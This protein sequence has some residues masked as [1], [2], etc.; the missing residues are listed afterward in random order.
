MDGSSL[1]PVAVVVPSLA[2]AL[3]RA[4]ALVFDFDGTLV[5]ST[6]IKRRAFELCFVEF[7]E[8]RDEILA[9]CWGHH[10]TPREV[11][12]RYVYEQIL[13]RPY[14]P[15]LAAT[16][17]E[18]FEAATTRQIIHAPEIPGAAEFL[19]RAHRRYL[20]SLLS[21]TPHDVLLDI[22]T[23]RGWL[24]YFTLVQGSPVQKA[25][26]L[27]SFREARRFGEQDVI[28]FGDTSEDAQAAQAGGAAFVTVNG[29]QGARAGT[30][31]VADFTEL[32]R[33]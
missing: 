4:R 23:Q 24:G 11:K 9:Y 16:L 31:T 21:S 8:R 13:R 19:R 22:L 27:K 7:P 33:P 17:H 26:W 3:Q 2:E 30:Y 29:S 25:A 14:T 15:E 12:F 28:F 20:M 1:N 10:H 5:D 6:P 18:R 32:L